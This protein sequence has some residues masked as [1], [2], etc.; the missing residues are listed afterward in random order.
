MDIKKFTVR[1]T[2]FLIVISILLSSPAPETIFKG[3]ILVLSGLYI[4]TLASGF[5]VKERISYGV[6][7]YCSH[8][9]YTGSILIATGAAIQM[10]GYSF[11]CAAVYIALILLLMKQENKIYKTQK[12][13]FSFRALFTF[14]GWDYIKF[15][16]NKE[17]FNWGYAG[18]IQLLLL[19]KWY[20]F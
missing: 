16:R 9:M 11:I 1:S 3:S 6:Y 7:E 12:P 8:P 19:I 5:L 10:S 13:F 18:V 17:Y 2:P 4:R 14:K 15:L 20:L